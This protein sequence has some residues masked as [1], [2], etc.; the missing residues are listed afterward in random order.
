MTNL[1]FYLADT[2]LWYTPPVGPPVELK[3]SY[4]SLTTANGPAGNKWQLNYRSFLYT[5]ADGTTGLPA[6]VAVTMADGRQD[7]Y[8]LPDSSGICAPPYH[9]FTT[10]THL[11]SDLY[12]LRFRDG[13]V[14]VYDIPAGTTSAV[15][16]LVAIRDPYNQ[17]LS[18][19]YD[20]AGQLVTMTDA[21]GR[22]STLSYDGN[23]HLLRVDDPFG[24]FASFSY[25]GAG[26]LTGITD[27][28]G[29]A[30]SFTYDTASLL[31]GLSNGVDAWGFVLEPGSRNASFTDPYPAP[32][33]AMGITSRIT[34]TD[35]AGNKEEY[36]HTG[37]AAW[38]V[39]RNHYQPYVDA[40]TNNAAS[41][42]PKTTYSLITT[43]G[44]NREV[45]SIV[46]PEGSTT[47][48]SYADLG[49]SN[50]NTGNLTG[51]SS[52]AI[53]F[54]FRYNAMGSVT[55]ITDGSSIEP[56]TT[57]ISYAANGIDP[58]AITTAILDPSTSPPTVVETL[59]TISRT[60][61]AAHDLTSETDR[62]G[63]TTT[64]TYN[65]FG[66]K[67]TVTDP[68]GTVTSYVYDQN[69]FLVRITRSGL[70]MKA[71]TY[72]AVGRIRSETD[73]SGITRTYTYNGL[74]DLVQTTYGDGKTM[75]ETHSANTPHLVTAITDRSGRTSRFDH[76]GSR[77]LT[78]IID[79]A[80]GST[81][82]GYDASGNLTSL[83][84]PGGRITTFAYDHDNRRIRKTFADGSSTTT[85]YDTA[86]RPATFT[87]ARG[88]VINTAYDGPDTIS[89]R[90]YMERS[91][92]T[93]TDPF[94][95][96]L[97]T[98]DIGDTPVW[99]AFNT[100]DAYRRLTDSS[101]QSGSSSYTYDANSRLTS[102]DGPLT[103]DTITFQY[104]LKGRMTRYALQGGQTVAYTY[105]AFDRLT[106]VT[107][108]TDVFTYTYSGASRLIRKLTRPGGSYTEYQYD[109]LGRLTVVSNKT[110]T[111]TVINEFSYTYNGEDAR[112][113]ETISNGPA[114]ARLQDAAVTYSYNSVNGL[115][116]ATG[117][118][119]TFTN[120]ADGN[121]TG[122]YATDGSPFT[123]VY[124]P[125]N[126]LTSLQYTGKD[127]CGT[128]P[129]IHKRDYVYRT[130]NTLAQ[131]TRQ[132]DQ[133]KAPVEIS[134]V[135]YGGIVLQER[136]AANQ[137]VREYTWGADWGGGIGG[138]LSLLQGGKR[139]YYLYDGRGNV[140]ALIDSSG[141][142]V[143]AYA[144]DP[145]GAP[146][147]KTGSL[148]QPYRFSTKPYDEKT[149]LSFFGQ[150]FYAPTLGR[151][152]TRDPMGEAGGVNLY[153]F[154][155][156]NPNDWLDPTGE[157]PQKMGGTYRATVIDTQDPMNKGR[158]KI[159][160]PFFCEEREAWA[161]VVT[162]YGQSATPPIGTEVIISFEGGDPDKPMVMGSIA[163]GG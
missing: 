50:A 113:S 155:R 52:Q 21:L 27:M 31:T 81:A 3:L 57:S 9:V 105:D 142:V 163:G 124:D 77:L 156:N 109:L 106:G 68:L 144:Y 41:T 89:Y 151:W 93:Y 102:I 137:M 125:I 37:S 74:D 56:V 53:N 92:F 88:K 154:A 13:T 24:R 83:T 45:S 117:P 148:D 118:A 30:T 18:F 17:Q 132:D 15:S 23:G 10:L 47:G 110:S 62:L 134:Y 114:I 64:I 76:S 98:I 1:N 127:L 4:N 95:G 146:L 78:R 147:A 150:R 115:T 67:T 22:V 97:I 16:L 157:E 7:L 158:V 86:G 136:N 69:H 25:D 120:D 100:H 44:A 87:N 141:A 143:A 162:P 35:P 5:M 58:T 11:G 46:T 160:M 72:D 126:R 32:G 38:H 128:T 149:G 153:A 12:E 133:S 139:Y 61:N 111:G 90:V 59:G 91:T 60:Y 135:G 99:L 121:L 48:L 49:P 82:L 129:C 29:Y 42:V 14:H 130:D 36:F 33:T 40:T 55:E 71:Y 73:G 39:D 65:Q 51:I 28:G 145:F 96:E 2:P 94:T 66:Q 161:P 54:G 116:A 103:S 107:R 104:D 159:R 34:V 20:S 84:D 112:A 123:A 63:A 8:G 43:I 101:G 131:E 122:G 152:L 79:T 6:A 26:N 80:G 108:G 140:T 138:L 70:T 19:G 119:Q 85:T 75:I